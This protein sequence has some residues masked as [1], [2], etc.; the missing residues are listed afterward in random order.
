[1]TVTV[2]V[3]V[4]AL[5]VGAV[6]VLAGLSKFVG[7]ASLIV[8]ARSAFSLVV[9]RPMLPWAWRA[10]GAIELLFGVLVLTL[11]GS[12]WVLGV[13]AAQFATV[14]A[15]AVWARHTAPERPCGCLGLASMSPITKR[16][17]ARAMIL[18]IAA[19][20]AATLGVPWLN[21]LQT[22]EGWAVI[23]GELCV[24]GYLSPEVHSFLPRGLVRGK[25]PDC[26][27]GNIPL[28][29]IVAHVKKS[30]AWRE[31]HTYLTRAEL[32]EYWYGGCRAFL[33]F[34]AAYTGH[35]ATAT[36]IVQVEQRRLQVRGALLDDSTQKA[37]L[38]VSAAR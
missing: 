29:V 33:Y 27:A 35:P 6:L 36:F 11:S 30:A 13:A 18:M 7:G 31:I 38:S 1:M 23:A 17:I 8:A 14:G 2:F 20:G 26:I 24:L 9:P 19:A 5:L 34:S 10:L 25:A 21:G 32:R 22:L 37:L 15:Y 16:T 3:G 12:R 28:E 4:Q